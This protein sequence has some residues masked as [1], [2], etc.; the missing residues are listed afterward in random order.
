[1][2]QLICFSRRRIAAV[3]KSDLPGFLAH[4]RA[5]RAKATDIGTMLREYVW[6][7]DMPLV[8]FASIRR[9]RCSTTCIPTVRMTDGTLAVVW[10]AVY[11]PFDE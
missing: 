8:V 11:R 9:H 5:R 1:M 10:D 6:P 7:D 2:K 4:R 3:A